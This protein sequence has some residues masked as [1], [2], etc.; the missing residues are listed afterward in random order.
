MEIA[1]KVSG[2]MRL[3][4]HPGRPSIFAVEKAISSLMKEI[5]AKLRKIQT[6]REAKWISLAMRFPIF[7]ERK[8][9]ERLTLMCL[10]CETQYIAP[11]KPPQ[12]TR[13][14]KSGSIQKIPWLKN[15]LRKIWEVDNRSMANKRRAN[16]YISMVSKNERAFLNEFFNIT[17]FVE[18]AQ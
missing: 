8:G 7:L 13:Y 6:I 3:H 16:R 15:S 17:F 2:K 9:A 4:H 12:T 5:L 11:R 1:I 10:P 14:F 18:P